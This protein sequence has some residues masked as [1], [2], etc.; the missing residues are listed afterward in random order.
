[1]PGGMAAFKTIRRLQHEIEQ[2]SGNLSTF[3]RAGYVVEQLF[4][5]VASMVRGKLHGFILA[6]EFDICKHISKKMRPCRSRSLT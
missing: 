2:A 1:M 6:A 5:E 3:R 4:A